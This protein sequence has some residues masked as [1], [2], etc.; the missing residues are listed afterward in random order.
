LKDILHIL[1]A[2]AVGANTNFFKV[3]L[4]LLEENHLNKE[5]KIVLSLKMDC[6]KL[7]EVF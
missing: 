6:K 3:V 7:C 1:S 2:A 5:Q 4:I